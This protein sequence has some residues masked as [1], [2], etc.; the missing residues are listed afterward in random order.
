MPIDIAYNYCQILLK[1]KKYDEVERVLTNINKRSNNE[2]RIIILWCNLFY[3][4]CK[5]TEADIFLAN[6]QKTRNLF[7]D[8]LDWYGRIKLAK[9][10][11][12]GAK[13]IYENLI[14]SF[15][16]HQGYWCLYSTCLKYSDFTNY[17]KLMDFDNLVHV[18][19]IQV[20]PGYSSINEF[21]K[22]LCTVLQKEHSVIKEPLFQSVFGGTQTIG[23][24]FNSKKKAIQTL[25][26]AITDAI[27]STL[28]EVPFD[29][30][31]PCKKHINASFNFSGAWSV[32]LNESGF[33]R[34]HYHSSGWYSG[35]YYV[36]TPSELSLNYDDGYLTIGQTDIELTEPDIP[37]LYIKPKA[38]QLVLFPSFFWHGTKPFISKEPR[39]TVAFD[40]TPNT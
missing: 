10:D 5:Y 21:N 20:P 31:H 17:T 1:L 24:L 29:E 33:H 37:D 14:F 30:N 7:A 3:A 19:D 22:E 27:H 15:P 34:N 16:N 38:G 32:W 6:L 35:V 12:I 39:V 40:I 26:V 36:S 8:E 13:Q 4:L 23:R 2:P 25:N 28:K 11:L 18:I 9:G